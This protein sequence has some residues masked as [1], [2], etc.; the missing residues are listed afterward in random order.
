[1]EKERKEK[2]I[3]ENAFKNLEVSE[4]RNIKKNCKKQEISEISKKAEENYASMVWD[5]QLAK[6][7]EMQYRADVQQCNKIRFED[8]RDYYKL[9]YETAKND[10]KMQRTESLNNSLKMQYKSL[11]QEKEKVL[12]ALSLYSSN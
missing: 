10:Q 7:K 2:K 3:I 6:A 5:Q 1:M 11:I 12:K 8:R 9:E 4:N